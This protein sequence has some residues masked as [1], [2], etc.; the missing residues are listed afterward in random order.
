[1][2]RCENNTYNYCIKQGATFNRSSVWTDSDGNPINLTDYTARMQLRRSVSSD[3]IEF[4]LTTENG[5]IDITP[6]EGIVAWSMSA[7]E[8]A[9]LSETYVYDLELVLSDVV[10]PYL[11]GTIRVSREVTR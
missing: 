4:E 11:G 8:T 7:T 9:G 2:A 5:G 1:M 6:L 3:V 10:I